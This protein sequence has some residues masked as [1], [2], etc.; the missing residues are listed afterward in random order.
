MPSIEELETIWNVPKPPG[1]DDDDDT[2]VGTHLEIHSNWK[3]KVDYDDI[4]L[5]ATPLGSFHLH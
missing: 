5:V 1:E 4:L 3:S 2:N